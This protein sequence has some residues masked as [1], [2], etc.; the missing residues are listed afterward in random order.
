MTEQLHTRSGMQYENLIFDNIEMPT[1]PEILKKGFVYKRGTVLGFLSTEN[2]CVPVDKK[3][4]DSSKTVYAVLAEDVDT[5][6]SDVVGAVYYAGGFNSK[7]LIFI[8]DNTVADHKVSA[9]QVGI[10]F[11]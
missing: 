4:S 11:K 6:L 9:R 2:K 3:A 1:G 8:D 10:F 5:T 7:A